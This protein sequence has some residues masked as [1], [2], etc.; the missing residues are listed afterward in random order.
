MA[1]RP[2]DLANYQ[3]RRATRGYARD[4]VDELLDQ[5][6]DQIERTDRELDELRRRVRDAEARLAQAL[7]RESAVRRNAAVAEGAASRAL[8]DA[9]EQ[10]DELRE[11]CEREVRG[12]LDAAAER[13]AQIIEAAEAAARAE[14]DAA[15]E[16]RAAIE[17]RIDGL[18]ALADRNRAVYEQHLLGQLDQ[19]RVLDGTPGVALDFV[20]PVDPPLVLEAGGTSPTS[21]PPGHEHVSLPDGDG[22]GGDR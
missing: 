10:A 17:D 5:I 19:L 20:P 6:A 1:L 3:L 22:A 7:E 13:A 11:A 4:Q 12:Q 8:E 16:Q 21:L 14:L 18:R 9:R 2:E 15:R